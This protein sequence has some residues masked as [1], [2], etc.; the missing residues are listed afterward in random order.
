MSLL[1]KIGCYLVKCI[2]TATYNVALGVFSFVVGPYHNTAIR[3]M[4]PQMKKG[5][6]RSQVAIA[7]LAFGANK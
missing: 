1:V 7:L 3:R 5:T 4:S 2:L 6:K